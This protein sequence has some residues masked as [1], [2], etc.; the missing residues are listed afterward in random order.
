MT[1]PDDGAQR[2]AG[3]YGRLRNE[4]RVKATIPG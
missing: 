4:H 3:R 1:H 2:F